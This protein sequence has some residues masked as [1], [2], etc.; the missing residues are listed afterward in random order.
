MNTH[1][2]HATCRFSGLRGAYFHSKNGGV[3]RL[4][5]AKWKPASRPQTAYKAPKGFLEAR[6]RC[7][8]YGGL[9]GKK[10]LRLQDLL[11]R[12]DD[13]VEEDEDDGGEDD[14]ELELAIDDAN[15]KVEIVLSAADKKRM[16]RFARAYDIKGNARKRKQ[17]EGSHSKNNMEGTHSTKIT[18][19]QC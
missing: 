9:K 19:P 11:R 17:M 2:P 1:F 12:N 18:Q 16:V 3:R 13:G 15:N 14:E 4:S 7:S 8:K 5:K 6:L 10:I